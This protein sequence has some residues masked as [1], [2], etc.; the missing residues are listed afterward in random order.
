MNNDPLAYFITWTVYGTF[1][2]GDFRGWTR[3]RNGHQLPQPKLVEWHR[4][5]L[6]HH[7]ELLSTE[8]RT[9]I[10][11]EID[12]LA[13]FRGWKVWARSARTNHVHAVITAAVTGKKVR[14]QL[15]ANCT[16]VIRERW[17]EFVGRPVWTT[18]G[19]WECINTDT[20]L[21]NV[22]IYVNEAQRTRLPMKVLLVSRPRRTIG[23]RPRLWQSGNQCWFG[24]VTLRCL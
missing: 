5:R 24:C 2:Q 8:K 6:K 22:I 20:G 21:E 10:E 11:A 23:V 9:A 13:S 3:R 7:I 18:G 4:V 14:D 19:D 16:R 12:R 1:L 17:P 15:K